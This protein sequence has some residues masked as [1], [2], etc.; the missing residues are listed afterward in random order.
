MT[1]VAET[2]PEAPSRESVKTTGEAQLTILFSVC[3]WRTPLSSSLS[4]TAKD[5]SNHERS[6]LGLFREDSLFTVI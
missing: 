3:Y 4:K 5:G 2:Q 1:I 6:G